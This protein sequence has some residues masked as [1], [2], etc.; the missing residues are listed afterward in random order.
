[1]KKTKLSIR[2]E[3]LRDLTGSGL[4][5]V[6]GGLAVTGA[7]N[8]CNNTDDCSVGCPTGGCSGSCNISCNGYTCTDSISTHQKLGNNIGC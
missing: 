4:R 6:I 5:K 2:K 3:T 8:D 1:M 7:T